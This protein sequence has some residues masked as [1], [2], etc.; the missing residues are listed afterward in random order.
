MKTFAFKRVDF[1]HIEDHLRMGFIARRP[2]GDHYTH[3]Y[4]IVMEW[5]CD[6]PIPTERSTM[7]TIKLTKGYE[8]LVSDEDYERINSMN[9][10]ACVGSK[11]RAA[12]MSKRKM[13]YMQHEVLKVVSSEIKAIGFEVDHKDGNTLNNQRDNLRLITH[14]ENMQ[15]TKR[16]IERV[17]F[18][19]NRRA[20][21]WSVYLDRPNRARKYLGYTKTKE[22]AIIRIAEARDANN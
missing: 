14:T 9:W 16:H 11:V 5:V 21:L 7:K 22:E 4:G 17:G 8:A 20:N 10:F 13:I 12:R 3:L 19:F 6:C 1:A 15:N 2:N 18:C